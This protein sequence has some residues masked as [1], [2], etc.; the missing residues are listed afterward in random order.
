MDGHC[1][2]R[3]RETGWAGTCVR[4]STLGLTATAGLSAPSSS[5][6]RLTAVSQPSDLTTACST[7]SGGFLL[8]KHITY[9]I[10]TA[11]QGSVIFS[12]PVNPNSSSDNLRSSTNTVVLRYVNGTSNLSPSAV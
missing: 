12:S 10:T 3:W 11:S 1:V 2:E 7:S 5:A 9:S 4:S 8:S 6:P